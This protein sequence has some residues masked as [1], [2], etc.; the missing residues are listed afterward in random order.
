M[1]L[2]DLRV[3]C[4]LDYWVVHHM[5]IG[6]LMILRK[7]K[8]RWNSYSI[9]EHWFKVELLREGNIRELYKY[10]IKVCDIGI[11]IQLLCFWTLSII[12]VLFNLYVVLN[13]NRT[14]DNVQKHNNCQD[15]LNAELI[16]RTEG[17]INQLCVLV[18][19]NNI[20]MSVLLKLWV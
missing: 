10:D 5:L 19:M 11:L 14:M 16:L 9:E 4:Q 2:T 7:L 17:T 3:Y 20:L 13:K 6:M 1:I 18:C 8:T 12:L 15:R